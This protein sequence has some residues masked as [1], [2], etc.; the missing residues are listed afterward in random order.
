MPSRVRTRRRALELALRVAA[1]ALLGWALWV[2]AR[3]M[4]ERSTR[5]RVSAG[6]LGERLRSWARRGAPDSARLVLDSLPDDSLLDWL[7]ATRRAGTRL[8]WSGGI[9]PLALAIEP[10]NAPA[11]GVRL[12]IAAPADTDVELRDAAGPVATVRASGGGASARTPALSEQASARTGTSVARAR[13]TDSPPPGAVLVL[14]TAGWEAR[15]V[16]AA[17]EESGWRVDARLTIAP[18]L[19]VRRG[20]PSPIDTARYA[21]VVVLDSAARGDARRVADYA[22]M[23]GGVVL[24]GVAAGLPALRDIAPGTPGQRVRPAVT[25]F[26]QDAPRRALGV[27]AI[28]RLKPD[29]LV[30]EARDGRPTIAARRA[31]LG[32]VLQIGYDESWRWRMQGGER[33]LEAHRGW[34]SDAVASAARRAPARRSSGAPWTAAAPL[35]AAFAALGPPSSSSGAAQ[36]TPSPSTIHPWMLVLSLT[37]LLAEWTSRRLRGA[38]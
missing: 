6:E 24:G 32:R 16:I 22:R 2:A 23:G 34:W 25:A 36:D 7:V 17:L 38:A 10:V 18:G 21:A 1:V 26:T 27:F 29:A 20:T 5:E 33:G 37:L 3:P 13:I 8:E 12:L 11:G 35:A 30:L 28:A 14:G 15:Y 4:A 9:A 31:D 19:V